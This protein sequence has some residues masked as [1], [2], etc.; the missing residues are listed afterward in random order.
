MPVWQNVNLKQ[1][2]IFEII[3]KMDVKDLPYFLEDDEL[4]FFVRGLAMGPHAKTYLPQLV[5]RE[6]QPIYIDRGFAP[7]HYSRCVKLRFYGPDPIMT[8]GGP[9][10]PAGNDGELMEYIVG[11]RWLYAYWDGPLVDEVEQAANLKMWPDIARADWTWENLKI[12]SPPYYVPE[13]DRPWRI[14]LRERRAASEAANPAKGV[15][16]GKGQ[17][18]AGQQASEQ[19]YSGASAD[20]LR[21]LAGVLRGGGGGFPHR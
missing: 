1:K 14:A 10:W 19:G 3:Q 16:K 20:G 13:D 17:G 5:E 8:A 7:P 18:K 9:N 6:K 21:S 15:G 12:I 11:W 4:D 2:A